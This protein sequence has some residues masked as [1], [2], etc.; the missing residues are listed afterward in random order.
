[1]FQ[2]DL[3]S[4]LPSST[5]VICTKFKSTRGVL[6]GSFC[7]SYLAMANA[8]VGTIVLGVAEK[9]AGLVWGGSARYR[10]VGTF[11]IVTDWVNQFYPAGSL[12]KE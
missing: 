3:L 11:E 1:M 8:P 7:E 5:K 2:L 10:A 9:P 12:S 4:E 6:R